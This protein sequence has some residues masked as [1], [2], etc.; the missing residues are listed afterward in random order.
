[1]EQ[2]K[3][4]YGEVLDFSYCYAMM[5]FSLRY[6]WWKNALNVFLTMAHISASIGC[7]TNIV[8]MIGEPPNLSILFGGIMLACE[9]EILNKRVGCRMKRQRLKDLLQWVEGLRVIKFANLFNSPAQGCIQEADKVLFWFC[10][11]YNAC[12]ASCGFLYAIMYTIVD[13]RDRLWVRTP[14]LS[15]DNDLYYKS[16]VWFHFCVL[17]TDAASYTITDNPFITV[18]IYLMSFLNVI[19]KAIDVLKVKTQSGQ[20]SAI[21]RDVFLLHME[22]IDKLNSFNELIYIISLIQF[23]ASFVIIALII[24]LVRVTADYVMYFCFVCVMM[25]QFILCLFGEVIAKKTEG[26]ASDLYQTD[27]YELNIT[28]QKKLQ[29]MLMMAQRN[30]GV[31]AGGIYTINIYAFIQM[32]KMA[33]TY[34]AL[35]ITIV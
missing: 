26:I 33:F 34:A 16:I 20:R 25:Q 23:T 28:D 3:R 21:L 14:F 35:L 17:T 22:I 31:K 24:S 5:S 1:M 15:E 11:I 18:G 9:V 12:S 8:Y 4:A 29:F 6:A 27:W 30:Y 32:M 2:L 13:I 10:L 7:I 19:N